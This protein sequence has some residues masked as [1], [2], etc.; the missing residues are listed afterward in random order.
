[1]K[2]FAIL[3]LYLFASSASAYNTDTFIANLKE[4]HLAEENESPGNEFLECVMASAEPIMD[5]LELVSGFLMNSEMSDI[6]SDLSDCDLGGTDLVKEVEAGCTDGKI[7]LENVSMCQDT[8]DAIKEAVPVLIEATA[9][10]SNFTESE[11]ESISQVV[12]TALDALDEVQITGIPLCMASTCPDNLDLFGTLG[13]FLP[14]LVE[15]A[16]ANMPD[17]EASMVN[18]LVGVVSKVMA[19]ADCGNPTSA[20]PHMVNTVTAALVLGMAFSNL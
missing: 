6:C 1:M 16:T 15:G 13:Q 19:G 9:G 14:M 11:I 3:A 10:E 12:L 2:S 5:S 17:E 18:L 4:R 8:I 7:I 20:S